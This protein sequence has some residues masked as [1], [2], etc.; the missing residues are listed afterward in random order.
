MHAHTHS[1]AHTHAQH[2]VCLESV[3]LVKLFSPFSVRS[4]MFTNRILWMVPIYSIDS[5]SDVVQW[6]D[7]VFMCIINI[8]H[9][10]SKQ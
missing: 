1:H 6:V 4:P 7:W 8:G 9:N 2:G 10:F 5:V 3:D